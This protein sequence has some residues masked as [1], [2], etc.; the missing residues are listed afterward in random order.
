MTPRALWIGAAVVVGAL[1]VLFCALVL[2]PAWLY[3]DLSEAELSGVTGADRQVQLQQAQGQLRN[4]ARAIL[5]QALGGVLITIGAAA[6]WRQVEVTRDGHITDRF[7]RAIEQLGNDNV[8]IRVGGMY[9]LERIAVNS[10][11]DRR[12]VQVVLGSYVRNRSPWAVGS[13]DGPEHPTSVVDQHLPWLR[14]RAPDI[15]AAMIILARRFGRSSAVR[16]YMSRVDLRG[17][18]LENTSLTDTHFRHS[19]LARAWMA[20]TKMDDSDFKNTDLRGANLEGA[21]LR[22][23]SFLNA[24]LAGANLRDADVRGADMRAVGVDEAI[25]KGAVADETTVWPEGFVPQL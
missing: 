12:M 18:Q 14:V 3:P 2:V 24:Y 7:T 19:N 15:Q 23:V 11:T 10:P 1:G 20:N 9:A 4:N 6:T 17:L 5:L 22:R 8:D 25:L 13:Q 21:S 16:V